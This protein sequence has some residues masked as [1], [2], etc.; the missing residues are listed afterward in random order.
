M[1]AMPQDIQPAISKKATPVHTRITWD[2]GRLGGSRVLDVTFFPFVR[3]ANILGAAPTGGQPL[4]LMMRALWVLLQPIQ[5]KLQFLASRSRAGWGRPSAHHAR[6][7]AVLGSSTAAPK[8]AIAWGMAAKR[9]R[10]PR[11]LRARSHAAQ[12]KTRV[13]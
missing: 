3:E 13:R 9:V 2:S 10:V 5:K 7:L 11:G 6:R 8:P 12:W 1:Y 4:M